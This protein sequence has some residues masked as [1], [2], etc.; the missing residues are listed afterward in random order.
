MSLIVC[1]TGRSSSELLRKRIRLE[2]HFHERH[3]R[4]SRTMWLLQLLGR[5]IDFPSIWQIHSS[6]RVGTR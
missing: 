4:T 5:S 2:R 6:K 3:Q 1:S